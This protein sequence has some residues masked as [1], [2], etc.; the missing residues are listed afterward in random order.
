M[1]TVCPLNDICNSDLAPL[2]PRGLSLHAQSSCLA[3]LSC[4][5]IGRPHAKTLRSESCEK[6]HSPWLAADPQATQ[7]LNALWC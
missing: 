5:V 4:V 2:T 7:R 1:V 3:T 6:S